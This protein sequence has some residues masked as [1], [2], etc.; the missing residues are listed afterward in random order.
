[1]PEVIEQKSNS[2]LEDGKIAMADFDDL[3]GTRLRY[4]YLVMRR[5][6]LLHL[7]SLG[8]TQTQCA[9]MWLLDANPSASQTELAAALDLDRVTMIGVI[10]KLKA[11][12]LIERT[13]SELDR[14]RYNLRLSVKG[15]QIFSE[16]KMRIKS[17]DSEF[18]AILSKKEHETFMKCLEKI[19]NY[20]R[21]EEGF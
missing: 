9:T 15:K 21:E 3:I 11:K 5:N 16:A 14:R 1:M 17:H 7:D 2:D 4:A 19:G 6:W 20:Q 8:L 13:R 12:K 10:E 18:A